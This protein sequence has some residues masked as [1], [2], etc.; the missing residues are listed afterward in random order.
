MA[1]WMQ[2]I[3][4]NYSKLANEPHAVRQIEGTRCFGCKHMSCIPQR[5]RREPW[6]FYCEIKRRH[7]EPAKLTKQDCPIERIARRGRPPQPKG[8]D[9][10]D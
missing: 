7:V 10:G 6:R 2:P 4:L 8:D 3:K 9:P 1:V 5:N